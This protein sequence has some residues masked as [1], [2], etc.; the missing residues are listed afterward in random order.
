M[1]ATT[2]EQPAKKQRT[3]RVEACKQNQTLLQYPTGTDKTIVEALE[4][5]DRKSYGKTLDK[6][7]KEFLGLPGTGGLSLFQ[8]E[9][10][11]DFYRSDDM[12]TRARDG[13]CN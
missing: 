1:G 7:C 12:V 2:I 13:M 10:Y 11:E 9:S 8:K 5:P 4:T 3:D 6:L